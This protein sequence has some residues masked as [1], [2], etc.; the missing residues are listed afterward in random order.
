MEDTTIVTLKTSDYSASISLSVAGFGVDNGFWL[1]WTDNVANDW[2]EFHE[3]LPLALTRLA[4]LEHSATSQK[5]FAESANEFA[6]K[7]NN[8]LEGAVN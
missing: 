5:G 1:F 3:T 6:V 2:T 8:F 4:V 7:A